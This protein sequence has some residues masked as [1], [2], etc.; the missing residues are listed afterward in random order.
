MLVKVD[1][2]PALQHGVVLTRPVLLGG[3]VRSVGTS[4]PA[5]TLQ[6]IDHRAVKNYLRRGIFVVRAQKPVATEV[7]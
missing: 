3:K 6:Q 7:V 2:R 5:R 1:I 4:I